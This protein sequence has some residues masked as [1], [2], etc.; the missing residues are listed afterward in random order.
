MSWTLFRHNIKTNWLI[1]LLMTLVFFMYYTIM[2]MMYD[3]NS[4]VLMQEF[5]EML[6]DAMVKALNF[7]DFGTTLFTFMSGYLYGF[8]IYLFPMVITVVVNHR[9]VAAQVDKGSLAYVLASPLSRGQIIRTQILFSLVTMGAFFL[10]Y[11]SVALLI[12]EI[13]FPGEMDNAKFILLNVNAYAVYIALGG[14]GF[15]ASTL[16]D[17][18]NVSLSFGVGIPVFF[19][20][21]QMLANADDQLAGFKYLSLFTLM[22]PSYANSD[23]ASAWLSIVVL[24]GIGSLL[25][26]IAHEVFRRKN[27]YV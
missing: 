18:K 1:W 6:P 20:I 26:G 27:F 16:A 5:I 24:V 19:L 8:L 4:L 23:P 12:A 10:S 2:L 22:D 9:L 17:D 3:P 15:L 11:T 7:D 25:Y 21:T 14:I 13:A